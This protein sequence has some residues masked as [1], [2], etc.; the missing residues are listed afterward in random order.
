MINRHFIRSKFQIV[1][2]LS[3]QII[4]S[5]VQMADGKTIS[6]TFPSIEIMMHGAIVLVAY[7]SKDTG[8]MIG[9]YEY[10]ALDSAANNTVK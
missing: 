2:L 3:R 6:I 4:N 10:F 8:E 7:R 5:F 9:D 1:S